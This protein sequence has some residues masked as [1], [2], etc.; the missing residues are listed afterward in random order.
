[1]TF[2]GPFQLNQFCDS[3][4]PCPAFSQL[5][6]NDLGKLTLMSGCK[7]LQ[8][9]LATSHRATTLPASPC[10]ADAAS[11]YEA[12]LPFC[13]M[14][15]GHFRSAGKHSGGEWVILLGC[16]R[17]S[18]IW[19]WCAGQAKL[20]VCMSPLLP[21]LTP[22]GASVAPP[23][24]LTQIKELH[25]REMGRKSFCG[26]KASLKLLAANIKPWKVTLQ[27]RTGVASMEFSCL[28]QY[29]CEVLLERSGL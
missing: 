26:E 18:T 8:A 21:P 6:Q 2:R 14:E 11:T 23:H 9:R 29:S 24:P 27:P 20:G 1:M 25:P 19:G 4:I 5:L 13:Q 17:L 10:S 12:M 22:N 15:L 16:L 7:A 28:T 3:M